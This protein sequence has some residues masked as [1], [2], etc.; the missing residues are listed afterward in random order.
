MSNFP[1]SLNSIQK[2]Q[3]SG[4]F[5]VFQPDPLKVHVLHEIQ[6]ESM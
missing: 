1:N 2:R 6:D 4:A 3:F 5:S